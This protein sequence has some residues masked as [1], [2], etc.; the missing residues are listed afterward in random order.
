VINY[1]FK[2]QQDMISKEI[3]AAWELPA[4]SISK[5][6]DGGSKYVVCP[7]IDQ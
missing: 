2:Y 6:Q 4:S 1:Q 5:Q 7:T 3:S